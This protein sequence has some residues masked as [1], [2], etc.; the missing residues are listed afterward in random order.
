MALHLGY[1]AIDTAGNGAHNETLDGN[2]L[3]CYFQQ[4]NTSREYLL[5]QS[6]FSQ[7][8]MYSTTSTCP[9]SSTDE[10]EV[11]VLKSFAHTMSKLQVEK[12][13]VFFLHRSV[14]DP[15]E[16][17]RVWGVMEEI[18]SHGG[19]DFLGLSQVDIA[20][21]AKVYEHSRKRPAVVQN[22]HTRKNGFD[23]EVKIYCRQRNIVYQAYGVMAEENEDLLDLPCVVEQAALTGM[24]T[25]SALLSLILAREKR[26]GLRFGIIDGSRDPH[27]METNIQAA[28]TCSRSPPDLVDGLDQFM[29]SLE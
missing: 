15:E 3:Q 29:I 24:A 17:I 7:Y 19:I 28:A 21:L 2:G 25:R 23:R 11:Q 1:R 8:D 22:R 20:T 16:T 26:N 18:A 12:L 14:G 4:A 10:L 13:D 9:Y 27:H 5:I 6:K